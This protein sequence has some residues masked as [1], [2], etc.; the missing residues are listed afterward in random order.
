M[1]GRLQGKIA[2]VMGAGSSGP[3]WG[4]GKA[5]AVL[6]AREGA[7]VIAADLNLEAA[8]ETAALITGEGL[9]AEA[10]AC[11]VTRSEQIAELVADVQARHGRIDIL[12][13]NVGIAVMGGPVEL[14]E[15][16]WD[17][18]MAVNL[19]SVFLACKHVIPVM[20]RQGKG[21]IV[22]VSSL[23]AIRY[24][25]PYASYYASKA[26]LNQLTVGLALQYAR[27][28]IRVNAIM[29]GLM[30]TPMIYRQISIEYPSIE[31][32]VAARNALC[33]TGRMGTA[34]DV[35][36]AAVFL[37]SDDAAYITGHCLPVDGGLS[38]QV[39]PAG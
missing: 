27:H 32:M 38:L 17:R 13:N 22:N 15:A 1:A 11:D 12:H 28:G 34:W 20:L 36:K 9:R 8:R 31:A 24:L 29:P 16:E 19:K 26:G 4:N 37:A 6:M 30:D 18:V 7:S 23:A 21:T 10:A 5:T 25:Y 3:G 14:D 2:L 33:P 39:A 35:A